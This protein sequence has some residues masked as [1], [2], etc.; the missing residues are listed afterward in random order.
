MATLQNLNFVPT[1]VSGCTLWLDAADPNTLSGLSVTTWRDKSGVGNN[2]SSSSPPTQGTYNGYP[3]VNFNGSSQF[4]TSSNTVPLTTHTLIAV[5][6]PAVINGNLQGNTSLF[7]FQA[8]SGP[9]VVFPYMQNTTPRGYI[10]S[11]DGAGVGSIDSDNS[12]LVENSVITAFN[13]I[14]AVISSG[15]QTIF[16]N[17]TQQSSDTKTLT[18]GTSSNLTIGSTN[19]TAQFYQGSLA[20]MIVYNANLTAVQRQQV[21]GY[22]AWK[23]GLQGSLPS[24]HPFK[25]IAPNSA[26]LSY[27]SQLSIPVQVQAFLPNSN[28]L[29]FYNPNTVAGLTLWL[30]ANDSASISSSGSTVTGWADKSSSR[31]ALTLS[32]G[33]GGSTVLSTNSNLPVVQFSNSCLYNA[34]YT[35]PLASRS[36]FLVLAEVVHS[37]YRGFISFSSNGQSDWN[38]SNGYAITSTNF[39]GS[40]IEFSQNQGNGGFVYRIDT[41]NGSLTTPFRLYEDVTS[42]TSVNIYNSGSNVYT[43][44][45]SV[46]PS[47]S[48]GVTVAGRGLAPSSGSMIV[49]EILCYSVAVSA[50]QRQAIEGYLAWKWG[51]QGQLP[52]NHPYKNAVPANNLTIPLLPSIV[53]P[54][55]FRPTGITGC[56]VWVDAMDP[57]TVTGTTN[58]TSVRDKA[59]NLVFSNGTGFSYV[60]G[61][62]PA[63]SNGTYA[64]GRLL[65]SN[66]SLNLTQPITLFAACSFATLNSFQVL[67]DSTTDLTR[68]GYG[69]DN[70][71]RTELFSGGGVLTGT[72]VSQNTTLLHSGIGNTGNSL[73]FINGTQTVGGNIG[74]SNAIGFTLGNRFNLVMPWTGNIHEVII[75][76]SALSIS[77]RQS[78]EG[79]L[80]WK[81]GLQGNL[82]STHPFKRF[83]PPP[84]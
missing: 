37:N 74:S 17:G 29:V 76:N 4:M 47:Q 9:Y 71:N 58:I 48:V 67:F 84:I 6:R 21:E 55:S 80:A 32:N 81:W 57:T 53:Q 5:H 52:S 44:T 30:D 73:L 62:Y 12:T 27:P 41:G 14:I 10:T 51:L 18:G 28:P 66:A 77:N 46:S 20:E 56:T 11:A 65:G 61:T 1:S 23:W 63:F 33:A 60:S 15:S 34:S 35:Y 45:T 22:L 26:G 16:R 64:A 19:G 68:I 50:G 38:T 78:V 75:Y 83:P 2:A 40:N 31:L 7:R 82:P 49:A 13:I 39:V 54:A 43:T 36:I 79:Y 3:V 70:S 25:L 8:S 72:A 59:S 69:I 24:N 42:G